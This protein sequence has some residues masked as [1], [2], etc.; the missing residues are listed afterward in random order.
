VIKIGVFQRMGMK[1]RFISIPCLCATWID[2]S[3]VHPYIGSFSV[4]SYVSRVSFGNCSRVDRRKDQKLP[5]DI[6]TPLQRRKY[7]NVKIV[8]QKKKNLLQSAL[9]NYVKRPPRE[10]L[11]LRGGY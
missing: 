10:I 9:S 4:Q 1:S 2:S 5:Q 7:E 11:Y 3:L 8:L 6:I